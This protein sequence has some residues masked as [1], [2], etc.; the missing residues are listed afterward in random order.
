MRHLITTD[1]HGQYDELVLALENARYDEA[2]DKLIL[3]GDCIDRGRQSR[4]VLDYLAG[5]RERQRDVEFVRGNHEDILWAFLE[6]RLAALRS[7]LDTCRGLTLLHSYRYDPARL[8]FAGE[9]VWADGEEIKTRDDAKAFLLTVMPERHLAV[10]EAMRRYR[11]VMPHGLWGNLFCCH[12]GL[13]H[14]VRTRE[15]PQWLFC[16]GDAAWETG[17]SADYQPV[18]VYG[19]WHQQIHPLVS[20]KRICL[21]LEGAVAVLVLEEAAI[22]TSDG[23]CSAL[24]NP[25]NV[26]CIIM[27]R[28]GSY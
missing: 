19:H 27:R 22:V 3:L 6:G 9:R 12:A 28:K 8:A 7:W 17:R 4:E 20:F 25:S 18:T 2:T 14:Q 10:V 5:L 26:E 1:I 23:L 21:A 15:T 24:H 11:V 13:M 16:W